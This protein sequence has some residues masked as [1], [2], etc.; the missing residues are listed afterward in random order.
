MQVAKDLYLQARSNPIL[1]YL[2]SL[3]AAQLATLTGTA[4]ADTYEAVNSVVHSV[5]EASA[6]CRP[7]SLMQAQAAGHPSA[8]LLQAQACNRWYRAAQGVV[9]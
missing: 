4:R 7:E 2:Q 3:E 1:S 8:L 9:G 6:P 5:M